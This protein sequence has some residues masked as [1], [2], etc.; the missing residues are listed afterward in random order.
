MKYLRLVYSSYEDASALS[1][2]PFMI[3]EPKYGQCISGSDKSF[4]VVHASIPLIARYDIEL[5]GKSAVT[6]LIYWIII[7]RSS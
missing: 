4:P 5:L 1:L 3:M 6:P 7:V 2:L